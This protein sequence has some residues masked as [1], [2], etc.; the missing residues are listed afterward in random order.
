MKNSLLTRKTL[1]L[2]LFSAMTVLNAADWAY[3]SVD[4]ANNTKDSLELTNKTYS[5]DTSEG[6]L[7][8]LGDLNISSSPLTVTGAYALNVNGKINNTFNS[9]TLDNANLNAAG[10][11]SFL[12]GNT[13]LTGV[14]TSKLTLSSQKAVFSSASNLVVTDNSN[15]TVTG[16]N[17]EFNNSNITLGNNAVLNADKIDI[18]YNT[19]ITLGE[20]ALLNANAVSVMYGGT[21]N[22]LLGKNSKLIHSGTGRM[23]NISSLTMQEGSSI[24]MGGYAHLSGSVK[25]NNLGANAVSSGIELYG[26]EGVVIDISLGNNSLEC[27][28]ASSAMIKTTYAKT[29]LGE[30]NISLDDFILGEDFVKGETY[31]IALIYANNTLPEDWLNSITNIEN[32]TFAQYVE[33][34]LTQDGNLI[35]LQIQAMPEPSS[36]AAIFA[37]SMLA[38]AITKRKRI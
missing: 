2:T 10:G 16:N 32:S 4:L 1:S 14:G 34:S 27:I 21:K 38:F 22:I 19:N 9:L 17:L 36:Y 37:L 3:D 13:S 15:L 33:G 29:M 24:Y 11:L 12:Y 31:T 7:T 28:D 5:I 18:F 23:E 26:D 25:L 20:N 35:S 8:I 6:E 30:I